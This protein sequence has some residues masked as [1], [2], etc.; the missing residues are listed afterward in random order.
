MHS[1]GAITAAAT[2]AF[3]TPTSLAKLSTATRTPVGN[4]A[5]AATAALAAAATSHT[6]ASGAITAASLA[7]TYNPTSLA[8]ASMPSMGPGSRL[9]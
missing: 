6:M 1:T 7:T 2:L 9:P 3:A 4:T 5:R 8:K